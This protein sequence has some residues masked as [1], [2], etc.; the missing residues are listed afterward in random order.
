MKNK[1]LLLILG[2]M[3]LAIATALLLIAQI[4]PP[5][6]SPTTNTGNVPQ[7]GG[8][9]S[10]REAYHISQQW[11]KD[12]ASDASVVAISTSMI[13]G[14]NTSRIWSFL[15]YSAKK[16]KIAAVA[17]ENRATANTQNYQVSVLREQTA[18]YPQTAIDMQAWKL[19]SREALSAW[20]QGNGENLWSRSNAYSLHIRLGM[21]EQT[22]LVWYITVL[23]KEG[24][25]VDHWGASADSGE[26]IPSTR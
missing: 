25:L 12:W 11:S 3:L 1:L 5:T 24:N 14:S 8:S 18:L 21:V 9:L 10:A 22:Q 7:P 26:I 13:K 19:D 23:D 2:T 17:I 20:W 6:T 15:I 4:A 16:S